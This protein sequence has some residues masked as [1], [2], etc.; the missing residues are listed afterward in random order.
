[1]QYAEGEH[2]AVQEVRRI[3]LEEGEETPA[4]AISDMMVLR[5][6]RGRKG[7]VSLAGPLLRRHLA[8]RREKNADTLGLESCALEAAKGRVTIQGKDQH[9][10]PGLFCFAVRHNKHDRD[11]VEIEN[12]IIYN[13]EEALK[14]SDPTEHRIIVIFDLSG[15]SFQCMD[16]EAVKLLVDILQTHYPEILSVAYVVNAPWV[17]NA[18]WAII[19]LW[20]D[21]VTKEKIR[22]VN[23]DHI[24]EIMEG[25]EIPAYLGA[26]TII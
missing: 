23:Q 12:L 3:L 2:V 6:V 17:F 9:G 22:F 16:Y 13:L 1:V 5:F 15:F 7:D 18:C 14:N 20:L 25:S 10:R 4:S 8:W 24:H 21:P 11:M 26:K 19:S